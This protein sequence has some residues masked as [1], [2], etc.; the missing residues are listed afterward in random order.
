MRYK[1]FISSVQKEFSQERAI[2]FDYLRQDALL[3]QFFEPFIFE[4]VDAVNKSAQSVYLKQVEECDIYLGIFGKQPQRF[5]ITSEVRCALFYGYDVEK[6]IPSYQVYKGD[7]F[8]LIAQATSFVLSNI[9]S[10]TGARDKSIQVDVEYELPIEA[11]REAIVNAVAHRDY[12]SNGSV[13]VMLFKDKLEVWNPR[14][15]P[16]TINRYISFSNF[17]FRR[18]E[19]FVYIFKV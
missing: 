7:V 3:G 2:L 12:T 5:F 4:K 10:K 14:Q 8:Q 1:I 6:P 17:V 11:V 19:L 18:N 16:Y 15:L 13:Q 9:L